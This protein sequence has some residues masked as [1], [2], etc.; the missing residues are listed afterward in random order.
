MTS[1]SSRSMW[2]TVATLAA[3]LACS[4]Y[5]PPP[6]TRVEEVVDT[7]HGVVIADPYRWLEEQDAPETRA[8]LDAQNEYAELIVGE[9]PLRTQVEERLRQLMD[10]VDSP[11]P[12]RAGDYQ[13]FTYRPS[14]RELPV[15]FRRPVPDEDEEDVP[16]DPAGEYEV[17]LDPHGVTPENTTRYATVSF[18]S[19]GKLMIYSERDGGQDEVK[20][21]VRDLERGVDLPDSLPLGLYA[22]LTFTEDQQGFYYVYRSREIGPR[23]KYHEFGT[24]IA[25]DEVVFGERYGP[26]SFINVSQ[27][28]DGR[29]LIFRVQHGWARVELHVKDMQRGG[30]VRA[31]VDD[32][33][34]RF[35]TR[36][37]DGELYMRTDLEA[38]KNRVVVVDLER[39]QR[40]N[41]R[42]VIPEGDDLMEDFALIDDKFYVTYLRDVSNHIAI[43]EKDGTPAG[44]IPVPEFHTASIRGGDDGEAFLTLSS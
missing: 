4:P 17:V 31:I 18:S 39:P 26:E 11:R 9:S 38:D 32:A 30:R 28:A 23:V 25:Q 33:D 12:Q 13:Y 5:P 16:I 36:F 34:A 22:S 7:L 42:E 35:Y 10:V 29:Y 41:W 15:I 8:W 24:D 14:G 27:Q 40:A 1:L 37:L 19:D 3:A 20:I 43:F 6:D 2:V 44:E 21:R